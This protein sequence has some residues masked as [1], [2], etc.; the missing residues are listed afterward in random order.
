[1][2]VA[3]SI[4]VSRELV[5]VHLAEALEPV[6]LD[7]AALVLGLERAQRGFVL[8]VVA[9]L[10]EV[11]AEQRRLRD[12]DEAVLH[13]LGD[14]PVEERQQQ[15]ADVAAVDVG[16]GHED[17]LVV[18]E[19][20]EV[21]LVADAGAD[22]L[23]QRLDLLVLEHPV[24]AGALDVEDLP[25]D[26]E[27]GLRARIA[28]LLGAAAGA[29]ALDDE[30]LALAGSFDEQSASLPGIADDSSSDLRRVRSRRLTRGDAAR[31]TPARPSARSARPS[32]GCCSSQSAS[33]SLVAFSTIDRIS[34][35]PSLAFVWPSN[36]GLRSFTDTIAVSPS[37]M[38]SPRRL[39]SL[40]LRRLLRLRV[41]V[42]HVGEG[43]LEALLVHA[44][45][46]GRDVVRERVDAL[47]VAG[48]PLHR[49]L[50]LGV[51]P[52]APR[53]TRPA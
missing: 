50:D 29:V 16:V 10:A 46:G 51:G 47:V 52:P 23:D 35:L 27:D 2:R 26:R 19:L 21:E 44:A 43:L 15:R 6:H 11:G 34:V 1:M 45:L 25:A 24:E 33:L 30:E 32:D 28:R 3:R 20:V 48:V 13:Q 42:D 37:R 14:L 41:L 39:S 5:P 17:D 31:V 8:E 40:S 22:R 49:D 4:V 12:V 9:L 36:C 7:L 53:R 18:A 38:S